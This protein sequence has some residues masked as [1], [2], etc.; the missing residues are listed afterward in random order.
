MLKNMKNVKS[1]VAVLFAALIMVG[2]SPSGSINGGIGG[3]AEVLNTGKLSIDALSIDCRIDE[4]D[5]DIGILSTR[6]TRGE[7]NVNEFFCS[8]INEQNEEVLSFKYGER[9]TEDIELLTGDYIFKI[10]SGE[11][12][13]AAWDSPVYGATKPF[14]IVRNEKTEISAIVCSLMQ[15]KVSVSYSEDLLER[16]GERT[17]TIVSVGEN[18]LDFSLTET[19]AGFFLAPNVSNNINLCISGTYAADKKNFKL[20]TMNKEVRDVK[21]GQYSKI[22][23]YIEHAAE[24]NINVGVTIR[25]WVTDEIVPCNVADLVNEEEWED[26]NNSGDE[27]NEGGNDNPETPA[28]D[29]NIVWEGHD[30]SKREPIVGGLS[31]DLLVSASKGIKEF[32]VKIE[33]ASLT[34][35]ELAAVG[36]CV[37]LNL[38]YPTQSYDSNN[39]NTYIDV[40]EPL[41]GLGFAVGSD[42]LNKTFVKLS[43]TQFMGVLQAVSGSDLKNHDFVLTVVDNEGNTTVKTLMLQTGK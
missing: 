9:P 8:I 24:G 15:I 26:D 11:I 29:P 3:G 36:L 22:H 31:V 33:S 28:E 25:D 42:V 34:P 41:R 20:I 14:K 35:E 10:V 38:C 21:A 30:I 6:A 7:V 16:L 23:L 39:P 5:P 32:Y 40:E 18:S 4:S 37:V 19:R 27:G 12:P 2:C 43:I 17:L 1:T 13:G